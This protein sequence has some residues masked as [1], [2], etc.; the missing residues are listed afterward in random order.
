[1]KD[2]L[3]LRKVATARCVLIPIDLAQSMAGAILTSP[4][5]LDK[6]ENKISLDLPSSW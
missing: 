5:S 3:Y 1:M 6:S 2:V 4:D